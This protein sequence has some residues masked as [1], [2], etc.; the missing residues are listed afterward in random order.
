MRGGKLG[1]HTHKDNGS[2]DAEFGEMLQFGYADAF[3]GKVSAIGGI[4][5]PQPDHIALDLDGAMP[6]RNLFVVDDD[7]RIGPA[8]N[9]ARFFDGID[10]T[11][12]R[13]G[14]H[15]KSNGLSRGQLQ[16]ARF[17]PGAAGQ[18]GRARTAGESGQR[19][20]NLSCVG[21]RRNFDDRAFSAL[22]T[23]KLYARQTN[24][25]FVWKRMLSATTGASGFHKCLRVRA[26]FLGFAGGAVARGLYCA[27]SK[28][29]CMEQA[30]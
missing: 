6:A 28:N 24:Q 20:K 26:P 29:A 4:H 27:C 23:L 2:A 18:P 13:P 22:A 30:P 25:L 3:I 17:I 11:A 15:G 14:D 12:R 19:G 9:D 1:S 16:R 5:I 10:E 8:Q 21:T 7:I